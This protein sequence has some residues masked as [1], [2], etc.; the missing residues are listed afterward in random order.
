MNMYFFKYILVGI[1]ICD[2]CFLVAQQSGTVYS[3]MQISSGYQRSFANP[4]YISIANPALLSDP[5]IDQ[6]L[7]INAE[8]RYFTDIRGILIGSSFSLDRHGGLGFSLSEYKFDIWNVKNISLSYGR[9][10]NQQLALGV[11]FNTHIFNLQE[12]GRNT[13][14][15]LTMGMIYTPTEKIRI[16]LMA[17]NISP[18]DKQFNQ[19][20]YLIAG[21]YQLSSKVSMMAEASRN[22]STG[23]WNSFLN[24]SIQY[25]LHPILSIIVG[26]HSHAA[27]P[28]IGADVQLS[29]VIN[30]TM[31]VSR[32]RYLGSSGAL[33]AAYS[34]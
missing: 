20:S 25:A 22:E 30:L 19:G 29:D 28:S 10:L 5:D 24:Y 1:A 33:S 32:H 23:A 11:K 16:S 13:D 12:F 14:Y 8:K 34:F 2:S 15:S 31:G 17:E 6:S 18:A 4:A 3:A 9:L 26:I 21:E 7:F 27:A